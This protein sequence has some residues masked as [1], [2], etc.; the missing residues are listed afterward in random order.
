MTLQSLLP[1]NSALARPM[2]PLFVRA[3]IP[4]NGVTFLSM[5]SGVL[6]G[7]FFALGTPA[8]MVWGAAGF[9][10]ANLLDECDG[11]V[12]RL[13]NSASKLGALLDTVADCIVH[14]ALFLGLGI[15]LH[16]QFPHSPFLFLGSAAAAGSFLSFVMD[17]GGITPWQAPSSPANKGD[18]LAWVT[19]WLRIDFSLIVLASAFLGHLSWVVW[20]GALGVFCFWIPSTVVITIR[21]RKR[22][23]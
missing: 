19:E 6:G 9:L 13:T 7:V 18:R 3:R 15:G 14:I 12:A 16:R 1:L 20:A 23:R 10:M 8:A 11:K 17:V 2:V 22:A 5:L 4:A 21:S